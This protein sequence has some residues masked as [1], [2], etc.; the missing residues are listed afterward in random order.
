MKKQR[1]YCQCGGECGQSHGRFHHCEVYE[2]QAQP[3]GS[4]ATLRPYGARKIEMCDNCRWASDRYRQDLKKRQLSFGFATARKD[5][6]PGRQEAP[7]ARQWRSDGLAP[8]QSLY[9]A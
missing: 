4:W 5:A 7:Q 8:G 2:G 3:G 6:P 9:K 1:N